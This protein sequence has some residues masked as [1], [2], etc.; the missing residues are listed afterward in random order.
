[1]MYDPQKQTHSAIVIP[2]R[3]GGCDRSREYPRTAEEGTCCPAKAHDEIFW[4]REA[5]GRTLIDVDP[6]AET[7]WGIDVQTLLANPEALIQAIHPDDRESFRMLF[8]GRR[9]ELCGPLEYRIVL[10]DT[11]IRRVRARGI[12]IRDEN[13]RILCTSGIATGIPDEERTATAREDE[14]EQRVDFFSI[15]SHELRTPLQP[16]LGYLYLMLD[17]PDCFGLTAEG[18]QFLK[19]VQECANRMSE[20]INRILVVSLADTEQKIVQPHRA[21]VSLEKLALDVIRVCDAEGGITYTIDIPPDRVIETDWRYLYEVMYEICINAVKHSSPPRHIAFTYIEEPGAHV[22]SISDNGPGMDEITLRNLF[23]PFYIHDLDNLS[24]T[25]GR[26][27]LGLTIAKKDIEILGG[28][29]SV[30]SA[31]H[32][33]ST[34]TVRLPKQQM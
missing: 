16:I 33:G 34:F 6:A 22:V 7:V 18:T 21:P 4:V 19:V 12:S 2:D 28:T 27:G 23:Q 10:Q 5:K 20:I 24:R 8:E 15:A 26:L 30:D 14:A 1:M 32:Q 29:I 13:G 9:E 3:I 17:S 31:P 11:T 25:S